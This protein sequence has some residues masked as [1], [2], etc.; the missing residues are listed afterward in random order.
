VLA[1][2]DSAGFGAGF[3]AES[4]AGRAAAGHGAPD[5]ISNQQAGDL[6]GGEA[7]AHELGADGPVFMVST[8]SAAGAAAIAVA[9]NLLSGGLAASVLVVAADCVS[10]AGLYGLVALRALSRD[11]CRP[12]AARRGGIHVSECAAALVITDGR[13]GAGTA[14]P[15][16]HILSAWSSNVA[17]Q[18]ARPDA[19]GIADAIT[20]ALALAG[21][22]PADVAHVNAHA[23][24]TGQG[25]QAEMDAL[26]AVL[27]GGLAEV[28]VVSVKGVVGHCQA[29][30]GVLE[31]IVTLRAVQEGRPPPLLGLADVDPQWAGQN[32]GQRRAPTPLTTAMSISCGLGGANA[33]VLVA[34]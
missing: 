7:M 25:D 13:N 26:S 32:F 11:G 33:A 1:S 27:G 4:G 17:T 16:G 8:A 34:A 12:F 24:G 5:V 28:P 19:E 29:A 20:H 14:T 31:V 3:A 22:S 10:R 23:A 2:T 21:R 30:A 18:F 6:A 15:A 9:T